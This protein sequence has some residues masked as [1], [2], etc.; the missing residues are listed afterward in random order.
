V[1][2]C[3]VVRVVVC[4]GVCSRVCDTVRKCDV[5]VWVYYTAVCPS[6]SPPR[7]YWHTPWSS[8]IGYSGAKRLVG[9][10]NLTIV[11]ALSRQ[12]SVTDSEIDLNTTLQ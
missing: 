5:W 3:V 4:V 8:L 11:H 6:L 2:V 9:V 12:R 10:M 7:P 1:S